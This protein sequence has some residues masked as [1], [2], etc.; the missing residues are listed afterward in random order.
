[1]VTVLWQLLGSVGL[2]LQNSANN[3]KTVLLKIK[4]VK[5]GGQYAKRFYLPGQVSGLSRFVTRHVVYGFET[6]RLPVVTWHIDAPPRSKNKSNRNR[7]FKLL[8]KGRWSRLY[9]RYL[10]SGHHDAVTSLQLI[11]TCAIIFCT[12][13]IIVVVDIII[14]ISI[15]NVI[16]ISISISIHLLQKSK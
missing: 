7:A 9:W 2:F 12:K 4:L 3:N 14:I 6:T 11:V 1:M 16:S 15:S 10:F 5:V 8:N 13:L